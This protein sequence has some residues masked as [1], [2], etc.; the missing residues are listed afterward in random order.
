MTNLPAG[1]G[2]L[3]SGFYGLILGAVGVAIALA[4]VPNRRLAWRVAAVFGAAFLLRVVLVLTNETFGIFAPRDAGNQALDL[5]LLFVRTGEWGELW[6]AAMG[7]TF[8]VQVVA[9]VP[10]F[11]IFGANRLNLLL[12]NAFV[13]AVAPVVAAAYVTRLHTRASALV[14]AILFAVYPASVNFSYFG[15]RDPFVF[16]FVTAAS[17]AGLL[18]LFDVRQPPA[19]RTQHAVVAVLSLIPLISLRIE[20]LPI[21][22]VVPGWWVARR[23]WEAA[24]RFKTRFEQWASRVILGIMAAVVVLP[25]VVGVY[26]LTIAQVGAGQLV[27]PIELVEVYTTQRFERTLE[28]ESAGSHFLSRRTYESL[29]VPAVVG[30]QT[31]G[32]IVLPYPWLLTDVTRWLA[33]LDSL[34]VMWCL[35]MVYRWGRRLPDQE[36]R[37]TWEPLLLAFI[38]GI[39]AMGF[40]VVNAGN[41]FR[42]RLSVMPFLLTSASTSVTRWRSTGLTLVGW[43]DAPRVSRA[44]KRR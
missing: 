1:L 24:T 33:F 35:W 26:R 43:L 2:L 42:M 9:N 36:R 15:L 31:L 11:S 5:Y 14:A 30:I 19:R 12:T 21:L 7:E 41:G 23:M 18:A 8:F 32:M 4:T 39:V 20:L 29:P 17:L 22:L 28:G 27:G 44:S 37:R 6:R 3:G 10:A 38:A 40:V 34:I 25:A 13:G 16:L